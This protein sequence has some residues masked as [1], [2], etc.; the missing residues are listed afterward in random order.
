MKAACFLLLMIIAA[1]L[2]QGASFASQ[3]NSPPQQLPS[4]SREKSASGSSES[5]KD[6]QV[7]SEKNQTGTEDSDAG[8]N[9]PERGTRHVTQRRPNQSHTKLAP[10]HQVH[11]GKTPV[12]SILQPQ[13]LEKGAGS[14]QTGSSTSS[15][16]PTR[17]INYRRTP[18]PPAAVAVNGQQFKSSR[19]P[20]ARLATS[21][22]PLTT[23][24][25]TAAI[26]GTNMKRRP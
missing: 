19:D 14:H 15:S 9:T 23:A 17:A 1:V 2:L 26:N 12:A 11:S 10:S 5:Q 24:R 16:A 7:R 21:G 8:Q 6:G 4:Q 25:G 20:G 13:T 22:G 18:V 3:S